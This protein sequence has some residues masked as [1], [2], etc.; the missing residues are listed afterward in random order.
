DMV[1]R[2]AGGEVGEDS[3]LLRAVKTFDQVTSPV[4]TLAKKIGQNI[5]EQR[6][7]PPAEDI[8]YRRDFFARKYELEVER[9]KRLSQLKEL[10]EKATKN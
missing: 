7:Q 4:Q 1:D 3:P 2:K 6:R 5:D 8:Q 9:D 10:E